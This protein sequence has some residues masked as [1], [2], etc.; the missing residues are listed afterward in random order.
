MTD[1]RSV[2]RVH[3]G[4]ALGGGLVLLLLPQLLLGVFG[5]GRGWETVV[6]GRMLGAILFALGAT[7]L[8]AAEITDPV[9]R[10]R[11]A[12]GNGACDLSITLFLGAGCAT[13]ALPLPAWLLVLLF[14]GNALSWWVARRQG[15]GGA[16]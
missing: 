2:C 6:V 7:L 14:G 3:A 15:G 10:R 5:L 9:L 8:A 1:Y 11:V 16:S 4:S 12:I 13:G